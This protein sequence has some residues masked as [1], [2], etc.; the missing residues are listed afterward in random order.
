[1]LNYWELEELASRQENVI[2]TVV[3]NV[4]VSSPHKIILPTQ[5]ELCISQGYNVA[6]P[7]CYLHKEL[8]KNGIIT[9]TLKLFILYKGTF[10]FTQEQKQDNVCSLRVSLT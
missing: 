10:V 2:L 9:N 4:F 7:E 8:L 5:F 1:M 3:T 6:M